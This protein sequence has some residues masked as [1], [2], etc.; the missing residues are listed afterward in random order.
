METLPALGPD[1][2]VE[3]LVSHED[4]LTLY[5]GMQLLGQG[6][7]TAHCP[8]TYLPHECPVRAQTN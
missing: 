3:D 8:L 7:A 4:P 5:S 6:Y 1:V 2:E